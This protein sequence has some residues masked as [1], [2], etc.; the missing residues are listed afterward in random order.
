MEQ[1]PEIQKRVTAARDDIIKFMREICAIPSMDSQ[2][3]PVGERIQA[4][5]R[6]LGY[7]EVRF[8]K[9]G[10]TL[11]RIGR[12]PKVLVYDSHI[13]TVGIGDR[14]EWEWDPFVG[15]VE[16]GLLYARGA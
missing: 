11:G 5:M 9:M 4:E 14:G 15:K 10:N 7:D 1:I 12:G 16:E 8:D 3:G 2:I 13:D 6:K